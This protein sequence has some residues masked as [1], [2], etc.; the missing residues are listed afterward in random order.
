MCLTKYKKIKGGNVVGKNK[1]WVEVGKDI[2]ILCLVAYFFYAVKTLFGKPE[3]KDINIYVVS[4]ALILFFVYSFYNFR[5]YKQDMENLSIELGNIYR[6]VLISFGGIYL[7]KFSIDSFAYIKNLFVLSDLTIDKLFLMSAF[8]LWIFI[9]YEFILAITKKNNLD[10]ENK[11]LKLYPSRVAQ[12]NIF[13]EY[14]DEENDL[15]SFI[16]IDGEW[17]I[18]KST[19]VDLSFDKFDKE[20]SEGRT[21][22]KKY[23]Y[24]KRK[25]YIN[26]MLFN[27]KKEIVKV[28]F[29]ELGKYFEK[30]HICSNGMSEAKDY[31]LAVMGEGSKFFSKFFGK[32]ESYNDKIKT[33][34]KQLKKLNE[35]GKQPIIVVDNLERIN[36]KDH[37]IEI[38]GFLHEVE[39]LDGLKTLVLAD[40]SKIEDLK[41]PKDYLDKFFIRSIQ[42]REVSTREI[43]SDYSEDYKNEVLSFYSEFESGLETTRKYLDDNKKKIGEKYSE[44][45]REIDNKK[46]ILIEKLSNPRTHQ[47]LIGSLD[48]Y[49][50]GIRNVFLSKVERQEDVEFRVALYKEIFK[51]KLNVEEIERVM[52]L[53]FRLTENRKQEEVYKDIDLDI[54]F[55]REFFD[56][57]I[58]QYAKE[59][60]LNL[61][62]SINYPLHEIEDAKNCVVEISEDIRKISN[63]NILK[64]LKY[65]CIYSNSIS[66]IFDMRLIQFFKNIKNRL[67]DEIEDFPLYSKEIDFKVFILLDRM[68]WVE[69]GDSIFHL[70]HKKFKK[71]IIK[72]SSSVC[73]AFLSIYNDNINELF[74]IDVGEQRWDSIVN[75]FILE[76]KLYGKF[77]K[78]GLNLELNSNN[79]EIHNKNSEII[80]KE[81]EKRIEKE[82]VFIKREMEYFLL[83]YKE[84][85]SDYEDNKGDK[86]EKFFNR[87]IGINEKISKIYK[88]FVKNKGFKR[89][90]EFEKILEKNGIDIG[91]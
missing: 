35:V 14:I 24:N 85:F 43:I 32:E 7:S 23:E 16:L 57:D 13:K 89:D 39:E 20:P 60:Y 67:I 37:I 63:Y 90:M 64:L 62:Y 88:E 77:N 74:N 54:L 69:D 49:R 28:L 1:L 18:G 82:H 80:S 21:K 17:G 2:F 51:E 10:I 70:V 75:Y 44:F 4:F 6:F 84:Y 40:R 47:K 73:E 12:S 34:K 50:I 81:I 76:D 15:K 27:N 59:R 38:L 29:N 58:K 31:I 87:I 56:V 26:A 86:L 45:I 65:M 78:I 61:L 22:V 33:I 53:N 25:I 48:S 5:K 8:L 36:D 66:N 41:I 11:N 71:E 19:F 46:N 72:N 9:Y 83:I 3:I 91:F 79:R 30:N 55:Y 68:I 42:L 52:S